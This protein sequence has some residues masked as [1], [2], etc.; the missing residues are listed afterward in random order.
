M[1]HMLSHLLTQGSFEHILSE[2]FK[3]AIRSGQR[4]ALLLS[5]PNKFPGSDLLSRWL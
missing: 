4:Q 5:L 3:Q 1:P 2:L